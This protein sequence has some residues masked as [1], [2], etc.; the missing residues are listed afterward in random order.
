MRAQVELPG[1]QRSGHDDRAF[2][3]LDLEQFFARRPMHVEHR[4]R[5]V[6]HER[7]CVKQPLGSRTMN[8]T[9]VGRAVFERDLRSIGIHIAETPARSRAE[10][11]LGSV[12][13]SNLGALW[14]GGR[15]V[16]SALHLSALES[17]GE[18]RCAVAP[19]PESDDDREQRCQ[20]T[21]ER[22]RNHETTRGLHRA[23]GL[24]KAPQPVGALA[25]RHLLC[26]L[27]DERGHDVKAFGSIGI[28]RH[29]SSPPRFER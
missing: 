7:P 19:P 4:A 29:G 21:G 10:L 9:R 3:H 11:D 5:D 15:D 27:A 14:R 12:G 18:I 23:V 25:R 17:V 13:E 24:R 8:N 20:C 22:Q 6:D 16:P 26:A 2:V 1:R 28:V